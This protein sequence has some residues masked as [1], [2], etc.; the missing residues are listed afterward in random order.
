MQILDKN[1]SFQMTRLNRC[2]QS[3]QDCQKPF[4]T[5]SYSRPDASS[6]ILARLRY[7]L[8]CP[9][10]GKLSRICTFI[11][12]MLLV[13][14]VALS[15]SPRDAL[16]GSCAFSLLVL[17]TAGVVAG[18]LVSLVKLPNILG[19]FLVG[20]I[21][22]N[23]P[24]LDLAQH[25]LPFWSSTL[26]N[27]TLAV[28]LLKAGMSLSSIPFSFN[29]ILYRLHLIPF[30]SE[31]MACS[32]LY[33][34]LL[35]LPWTWSLSFGSLMS[36]VSTAVIVSQL[37]KLQE[38][39]YGSKQTI[40]SQLIVASLIN[41]AFA[42]ITGHLVWIRDS[43]VTILVQRTLDPFLEVL[44]GLVFGM[45]LWYIP[46][47][48][49]RFS[50][51]FRSVLM[52]LGGFLPLVAFSALELPANGQLCVLVIGYMSASR[53]KKERQQSG[54]TLNEEMLKLIGNLWLVLRPLYFGLLGCE[55][56]L[57]SIDRNVIG[58]ICIVLFIGLL[59]RN[60]S[61]FLMTMVSS[62]S[63]NLKERLFLSMALMP[64]A[65]MQVVLSALILQK[66][67]EK[68]WD[69]TLLQ[70]AYI[71]LNMT[72]LVSF[73]TLPL[74][75]AFIAWAGPYLLHERARFR[76]NSS[77]SRHSTKRTFLSE[78]KAHLEEERHLEEPLFN[79]QTD[80]EL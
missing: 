74:G 31:F 5:K 17:F 53:W 60:I 63:L 56:N 52:L 51:F 20:V 37:L 34:Y 71:V 76:S 10:H 58:L 67:I 7:A 45:V 59:C 13:W 40:P 23:F 55:L 54:Q 16:P 19:M 39:N 75:A 42:L 1:E 38:L 65:D 50:F 6:G 30:L 25:I 36:G 28:L 26:R 80:A 62:D 35:G 11:L 72:V 15:V 4:Q 24:N 64:K 8:L 66:S 49:A 29:S 44:I 3:T 32:L 48:E 61:S 12:C 41:N 27:F 73:C 79:E 18:K 69:K 46:P 14:L 21:F 43:N 2:R 77:F 70:H 33:K 9:P 68:G 78:G 47:R 22:R 57:T